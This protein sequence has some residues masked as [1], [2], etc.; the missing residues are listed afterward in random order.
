MSEEKMIETRQGTRLVEK[1]A[2][3]TRESSTSTTSF[4]AE[5][6]TNRSV[7]PDVIRL[8]FAATFQMNQTRIKKRECKNKLW[9]RESKIQNVNKQK[10]KR[11]KN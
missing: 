10:K 7:R 5:A 6:D 2:L 9:I 3:K 4:D 1:G 8:P 11:K